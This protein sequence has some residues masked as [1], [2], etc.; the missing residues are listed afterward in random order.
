MTGW[1]CPRCSAVWAPFVDRCANCS[2]VTVTVGNTVKIDACPACGQMR[3]LPALTGC[4]L[5]SHYGTSCA[6]YTEES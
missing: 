6:T 5:G 1:E 3:S 4:P 2:G